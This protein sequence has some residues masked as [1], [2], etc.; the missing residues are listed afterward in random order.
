VNWNEF[1]IRHAQ[2]T[3]PDLIARRISIV[4]DLMPEELA[5]LTETVP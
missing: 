5:T 4:Y 2:P 1:A 3:R